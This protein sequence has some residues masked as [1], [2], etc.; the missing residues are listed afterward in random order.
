[1][2]VAAALTIT[3]SELKPANIGS[4]YADAVVAGGG[5][6][7]YSYA[8]P[9]GSLPPGLL[10][11]TATGQISGTATDA[12]TFRFS[13]RVVD[14]RGA[15]VEREFSVTVAAGLVVPACP[16]PVAIEGQSYSS[17]VQA[18]LGQPPYA[19]SIS[20]GSLPTG[21]TLNAQTGIVSG[22]PA[23]AGNAEF[24]LRVTDATTAVATRACSMIVNQ[25]LLSIRSSDVLPDGFVGV[26]YTFEFAATGGRGPYK[27][28]IADGTLPA[29][30]TM[31]AA[32][33]VTGSPTAT[34]TFAATVRLTDSNQTVT[35]QQV[36]ITV[37]PAAAPN[38]SFTDFPAIVG[39]AQQVRV[40][41]QLDGTYPAALDG[42]VRMTFVPDPGIDVDD[43][44]IQFATGGRRATF[45]VGVGEQNAAFSIPELLLQT[46]TVAGTIEL[47]VELL[48]DGQLVSPAVSKS[49]R[50]DR[51]AP[52]ITRVQMVRT[53]AGFEIRVTG[54]STTR[55][56]SEATFR[57]TPAPGSN[58]DDTEITLP[59]TGASKSWF[60]DTR[61]HAFGSQF[62]LVQP[63][64]VENATLSG[65]AVT[66]TN[67][68]GTSQPATAQF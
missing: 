26:A 46:G 47:T 64:T 10:L 50:I 20:S 67:G 43:A 44:S 58:L 5:A 37:R 14:V 11:S 60:T 35:S 24:T 68:Q 27:W 49:L 6:T 61:S 4:V 18:S 34:G 17:S 42:Q 2:D 65:V 21:L 9:S 40:A 66:L 19:W 1:M 54:F 36:S 57:F 33:K 56:V 8:T 38:V 28:E 63:F 45:R 48:L 41:L 31:D 13:V 29:G 30:L 3:T 12:G 39:P 23:Q 32:G 7:P 55:D 16:A 62:L 53:T 22:T 15:A 51:L 25:P 52:R 59:M